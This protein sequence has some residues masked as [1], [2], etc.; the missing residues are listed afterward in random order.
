MKKAMGILLACMILLS[1][2]TGCVKVVPIN[3]TGSGTDGVDSGSFNADAYVQQV[4]DS[5]AIPEFKEKA[6]DLST[7]MKEANGDIAS[8]GEKYGKRAMDQGSAWN[9]MVKG[10]A[11]VTAVN[12]ELRAGTMDVTLDG[13]TGSTKITLQV[14]PV[15][16]GTAIRDSLSFIKFD[17]YK[18]QVVYAA[19]SNAIHT[20]LTKTL[21]TKVDVKT[22]QGKKIDFVGAFTYQTADQLLITPV[23]ITVK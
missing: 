20:N 8:V 22:L 11:T 4:W 18:N 2:L 1:S 9:F 13:Y 21:F 15:F 19:L 16:K 10:T 7:I 12:T 17:D 6:A 3:S 14:G 5:K 23:D